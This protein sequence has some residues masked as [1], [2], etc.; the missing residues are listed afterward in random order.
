MAN[1]TKIEHGQPGWD[2]PLNQMLS[3]LGQATSDTGWVDITL[4]NGFQNLSDIGKT[5]V[6]KI[7]SIVVLRVSISGLT[8]NTSIGQTPAAFYPK[9]VVRTSMRGKD[10]RLFSMHIS[11]DGQIFFENPADTNFDASDYVG[12]TVTW[13]VG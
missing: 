7:G 12:D 1:I 11:T 10:G 6:R 3:E 4:V 2:T 9:Q 8:A 13:M 5:S